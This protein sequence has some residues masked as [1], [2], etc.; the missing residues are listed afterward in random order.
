MSKRPPHRGK[1]GAGVRR[2]RPPRFLV[3]SVAPQETVGRAATP[4][5]P[6]AATIVLREGGNHHVVPVEAISLIVAEGNYTHVHLH[7]GEKFFLTRA[8]G[9]WQDILPSLL[10]LRLD[11]SILVNRVHIARVESFSPEQ[12][13]LHVAAVP[14]P[15]RLGRVGGKRLR[16]DL[17]RQRRVR[18]EEALSLAA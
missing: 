9:A 1:V 2:G 15:V 11:R 10:F 17:D 6:P 7:S 16:F 18:R 8:I 4:L 13:L 3:L 5:A 12:T 14:S